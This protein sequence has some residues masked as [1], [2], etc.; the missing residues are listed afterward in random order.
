[1]AEAGHGFG[2]DPE[3]REGARLLAQLDLEG[4]LAVEPRVVREVHARL[5]TAAELV[6]DPVAPDPRARVLYAVVPTAGPG[7]GV[8]ELVSE[9]VDVATG[10]PLFRTKMTAFFRG[11]GGFGSTGR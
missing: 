8:A 7:P 4:D 9:S 5:T 10:K 11:E 3:A 2:L 1:M 6:L